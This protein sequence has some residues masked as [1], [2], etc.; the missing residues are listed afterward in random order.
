MN[1]AYAT[2]I[3]KVIDDLADKIILHDLFMYLIDEMEDKR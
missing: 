2:R 1:K 3:R